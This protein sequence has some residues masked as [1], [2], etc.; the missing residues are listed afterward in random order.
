MAFEQEAYIGDSKLSL[1]SAPTNIP[2]ALA[3][4]RDGV[5]GSFEGSLRGRNSVGGIGAG[6]DGRGACLD[7]GGKCQ[8]IIEC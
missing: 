6:G 3:Y 4:K 1:V 5:V 2:N 8:R 7:G